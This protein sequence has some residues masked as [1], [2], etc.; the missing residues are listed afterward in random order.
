MQSVGRVNNIQQKLQRAVTALGA[1]SL[2]CG[3]RVELGDVRGDGQDCL[4][5]CGQDYGVGCVRRSAGDCG[6][7]SPAD[8][9]DCG[10]PD[11]GPDCGSDRGENSS[12]GSGLDSPA[13]CLQDHPRDSGRRDCAGYSADNGRGNLPDYP[14]GG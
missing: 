10:P 12:A 9:A 14:G 6:K 13:D 4:A 3:V 8:D 5:D 2:K 7:G 1:E 11:S